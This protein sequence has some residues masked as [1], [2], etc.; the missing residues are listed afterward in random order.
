MCCV[1][2]TISVRT[3]LDVGKCR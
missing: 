1:A 3:P 2:L